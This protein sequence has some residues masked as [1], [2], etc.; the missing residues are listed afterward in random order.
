[1]M[2]ESAGRRCALHILIVCVLTQSSA[3][4]AEETPRRLYEI[5]TETTMPHLEESLR[6]TN[7]REQRCLAQDQLWSAFPVLQHAALKGCRLEQESRQ[8]DA[9]S[10]ALICDGGN[11]TTGRAIW[12][13]ARNQLR[14]TLHV[15]LGGKNMT[16]DQTV[17]A[18]PLGECASSR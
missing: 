12:Q 2:A 16:F 8:Q 11:G 5:T 13:P 7:T 3:P 9:L 18:R 14:G 6:Y 4:A 15:K 17:T 1:M 10:Y